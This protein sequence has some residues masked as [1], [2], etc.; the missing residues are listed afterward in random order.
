MEEV[1]YRITIGYKLSKTN[2]P[3]QLCR[4]INCNKLANK[5]IN[6]KGVCRGHY[7]I[8]MNICTSKCTN[9]ALNDGSGKCEIHR[10]HK[11]LKIKNKP[12]HKVSV[13]G[14]K[15]LVCNV[16]FCDKKRKKQGIV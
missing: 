8:I 5:Y 1:K 6:K 15:Y 14:E 3:L 16:E 10:G 2:R 13:T 9:K 12:I 7:K 11:N 4:V